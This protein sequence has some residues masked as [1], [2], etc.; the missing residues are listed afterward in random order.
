[1]VGKW[2]SIANSFNQF[3]TILGM[4]LK[5]YVCSQLA[6]NIPHSQVQIVLSYKTYAE[7][8]NYTINT[9]MHICMLVCA[10]QMYMHYEFGLK[11]KGEND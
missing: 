4:G 2:D 5:S 8:K 9:I 3:H 1:L 6:E 10:V 11:L 7:V